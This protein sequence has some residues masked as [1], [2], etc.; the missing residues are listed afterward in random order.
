LTDPDH[1]KRLQFLEEAAEEE[2]QAILLRAYHSYRGLSID[3]IISRLLGNRAQSSRHHA[4]LFFAWNKCGDK[5]AL[6]SW[7]KRYHPVSPDEIPRIYR[8]YS[9]PDL[10]I[11]DFGYL[12]S[13]H[14]LQVWAAGELARKPDMTWD[15]LLSRSSD[16]QRISYS[17]LFRL[18]NRKA[19]D[20]RLRIRIEKDAFDRM[21]LYWRRLGFPFEHLVPSYATAIG[22]SSD[23]PL[24]L[25][26]FMGIIVNDGMRR[27]ALSL[28]TLRFAPGTPYE[29]ALKPRSDSGERVMEPEVARALKTVLAE[30]VEL[31]T[32]NRLR[33]AFTWADGALVKVGGKTGSGDNRY[34]TFNRHGHETSSRVV[35]RTAAFVFY[36]GD[37]YYGVITAFV[38]GRQAGSFSFTSA[39]PVTAL[40]MLAPVINPR[41]QKDYYNQ[42]T[43]PW[44]TF[45]WTYAPNLW[46][47]EF[48]AFVV[49]DNPKR[50]KRVVGRHL[51]AAWLQSTAPRAPRMP[52]GLEVDRRSMTQ[53]VRGPP[54]HRSQR[55]ICESV[56]VKYRQAEQSRHMNPD[57]LTPYEKPV[58]KI[59]K[60]GGGKRC[61]AIQRLL[62]VSSFF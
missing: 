54:S 26:D 13:V 7:L 1:P 39:L 47:Y 55:S 35:S 48:R 46:K 29:T 28:T 24:A 17:W 22:T 12:L 30:V 50:T 56:I 45:L 53:L 42:D 3:A 58:S 40:R 15:E 59:F 31:G 11:A 9:N 10:N 52:L 14:P 16:A 44:S 19:Q 25:A 61:L 33:G 57:P 62:S 27:P 2:A 32:A 41:L 34:K 23:R 43:S 6:G 18:R 37:R 51:R 21:T 38:P 5:E 4:I 8:A 20:L 49:G 36:I 60:K